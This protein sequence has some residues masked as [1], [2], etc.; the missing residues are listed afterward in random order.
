MQ[1]R[2]RQA[3]KE[4][5]LG[6]ARLHTLSGAEFI[7]VVGN[8]GFVE[9]DGLPLEPAASSLLRNRRDAPHLCAYENVSVHPSVACVRARVRDS[10]EVQAGIWRCKIQDAWQSIT[11]ARGTMSGCK[12]VPMPSPLPCPCARA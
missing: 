2:G 9:V 10:L 5:H 4:G 12:R 1:K 6:V 8:G 7:L 11:R 3:G